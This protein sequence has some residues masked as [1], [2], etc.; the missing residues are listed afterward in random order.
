MDQAAQAVVKVLAKNC[1]E[2]DRSATGFVW[3]SPREVVTALHAV[4]GCRQL[5]VQSETA[6]IRR[7]ARIGKIFSAADLALL[8]IE[9]PPAWI[10]LHTSSTSPQLHQVLVAMGYELGAPTISSKNLQVSYGSSRLSDMLP[11][12]A[13]EEVRKAG[14]PALDLTVLRLQGH[15]L[16]GLSG[17]PILN[18]Q[19]AVVAI[20]D[21]GLESGAASI[22]WALPVERLTDLGASTESIDVARFSTVSTL[23]SA[24]TAGE[25]GTTVHCGD[26]DLTMMRRR[27]YAELA[28]T[29]DDLTGLMQLQQLMQWANIDL[30]ALQF[31][32][33]ENRADGAAVVIPAEMTLKQN[34]G[35]CEAETASGSVRILVAG[36]TANHPALINQ[37]SIEFEQAASMRFPYHWLPDPMWSYPV[38]H[39]RFDGLMVNRKSFN[40]YAPN[41][42]GLWSGIAMPQAYAFE[43]LMAREQ[44]FVG[45]LAVNEEYRALMADHLLL[46]QQYPQQASCLR[47]RATLPQWLAAVIAVFLSTFPIG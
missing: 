4:A 17:A 24:G 45:V 39:S 2:Q 6:G 29:T 30:A 35:G 3:H 41:D 1:G 26:L 31:D 28:A 23:F 46:C 20:S 9:D 25:A 12:P 10:P 43:T 32:I 13:R 21:G 47:L 19:G 8:I 22:S 16:P 42:P 38:P 7:N 44:S 37:V 33:Y 40:G 14:M 36:R 15:L 5:S 27:S 11:A 18:D 34:S